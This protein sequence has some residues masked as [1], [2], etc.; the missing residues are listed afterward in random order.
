MKSI[1]EWADSIGE[2]LRGTEDREKRMTDPAVTQRDKSSSLFHCPDC[3]TV[4]IAT[5]KDTCSACDAAVDQVPSTLAET[6]QRCTEC[7]L[8]HLY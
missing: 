7:H 8:F 5:D 6:V 1:I 4:Y 3:K 2:R